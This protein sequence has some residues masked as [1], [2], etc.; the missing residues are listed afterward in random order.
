MWHSNMTDEYFLAVTSFNLGICYSN[1][2]FRGRK[3]VNPY[4]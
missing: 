4:V 2:N 1:R 3:H